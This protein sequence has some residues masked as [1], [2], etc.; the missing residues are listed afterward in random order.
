MLRCLALRRAAVRRGRKL[1][2]TDRF[3]PAPSAPSTQTDIDPNE[4][5]VGA[6]FKPTSA[7]FWL[8]QHA[9]FLASD[10]AQVNINNLYSS[11]HQKDP[12]VQSRYC[13]RK[14]RLVVKCQELRTR[15]VSLILRAGAAAAADFLREFDPY[16][17]QMPRL[18]KHAASLQANQ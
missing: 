11:I 5:I 2:R 13:K 8:Q 4:L 6:S 16:S 18:D 7:G 17:T 15:M 1:R 14:G 9:A 10:K 12:R 3:L